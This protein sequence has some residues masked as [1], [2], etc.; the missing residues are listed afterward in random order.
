MQS[1]TSN[2]TCG[3][4]SRERS[5][6]FTESC[7]E[8]AKPCSHTLSICDN[9]GGM[10]SGVGVVRCSC[11]GY[12]LC[13]GCF[14]AG[15]GKICWSDTN[16]CGGCDER[17]DDPYS[18][19]DDWDEEE[20]V[21]FIEFEKASLD[22]DTLVFERMHTDENV[23][24]HL[25][26]HM[27]LTEAVG[28]DYS[29]YKKWYN[30][31]YNVEKYHFEYVVCDGC[32]AKIVKHSREHS[33]MNKTCNKKL[34]FCKEC[35]IDGRAKHVAENMHLFT[36]KYVNECKWN[37]VV[38]PKS[39]RDVRMAKLDA[40]SEDDAE[41]LD[42]WNLRKTKFFSACIIQRAWRKYSLKPF[43]CCGT[44]YGECSKTC[45]RDDEDDFL[46]G[47]SCNANGYGPEQWVCKDCDVV[48][49]Y[50]VFVSSD[51]DYEDYIVSRIFKDYK[52]A[53]AFFEKMKLEHPNCMN[54][55][56]EG[57]LF[58]AQADFY[59][60]DDLDNHNPIVDTFKLIDGFGPYHTESDW[61]TIQKARLHRKKFSSCLKFLKEE[62]AEKGG[63]NFKKERFNIEKVEPEESESELDED[64][65]PYD[66]CDKC[67][68]I[69]PRQF[70]WITRPNGRC[71][72]CV[73]ECET[74]DDE[75]DVGCDTDAEC[76]EP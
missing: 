20:P 8:E 28:Y 2:Q 23:L 51:D 34:C 6:S 9:Y 24:A 7:G 18:P 62:P 49:G 47:S 1:V 56:F 64:G 74:N 32:S 35:C 54:I 11:C 17:S 25:L 10:C 30:K 16:L 48:E 60:Y 42:T 12:S 22:N 68:E 67:G 75:D 46:R 15:K 59:P 70:D 3:G 71:Y 5:Q 66:R 37:P 73:P 26:E 31:T 41:G 13:D 4:E 57:N 76:N 39:E 29:N 27:D 21:T 72:D 45:Y 44:F 14:E 53:E 19:N 52:E 36:I 33:Y 38:P 40:E 58:D 63:A 61:E 43:K 55:E 50:S 69:L 65:Y